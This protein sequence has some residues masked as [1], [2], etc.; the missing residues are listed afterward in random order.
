MGK[1]LEPISAV[2]HLLSWL[3]PS[4]GAKRAVLTIG[5]VLVFT[6]PFALANNKPAPPNKTLSGI[7]I[8]ATPIAAFDKENPQAT[9][10]GKLTWRGGLVLR[11]AMPSFGGWSGLAMSPEGKQLVAVSDAGTWMTADLVYA[12]GKLTALKSARLGPL[13]SLSGLPLSR[14]RDRDAEALTLANGGFAKGD[15]LISFERKHRVGLFG[16]G[17]NGISA[18]RRYLPLPAVAKRLNGNSGL[19]G[20]A[21]LQG[22]RFKGSLVAFSERLIDGAGGLAGWIW[23][24]GK[25]KRFKL[26]NGGA[27]SVTDA[28]PLPDGGLLVLERR[29]RWSEGVKAR[30]RLIRAHELRPGAKIKGELLLDASQKHQID[31]MEGLAVHT[32]ADG[33]II[34]TMISDDNFNRVLQRTIFLQ[35]ALKGVD[36]ARAPRSRLGTPSAAH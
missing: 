27:F 33:E 11:S 29:F 14:G 5:V 2:G 7:A 22:G 31:N 8:R 28:A 23:V 24:D 32:G 20:L 26:D 25:P 36:I 4:N 9:N 12:G 15:L 35:F 30:L 34:V 3:L 1:T 6:G 17:K 18:P 16:I 13:K 21:V 10:F 19:E